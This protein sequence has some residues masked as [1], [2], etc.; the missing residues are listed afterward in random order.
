MKE[1]PEARTFTAIRDWRED[2]K[3]REKLLKKGAESLSDS[4]LLAILIRHG[5][6]GH[7]AIDVAVDLLN[8]YENITGLS[9][10]SAAEIRK[11]KGLGQ[12]KAVTIAAAFELG[13]RIEVPPFDPSNKINQPGDIARFYIPKFRNIMKENFLVLLLNSSN[14]VFKEVKISEGSLNASIV[15]PREVFKSAISESAAS[16]ILLHNHPSGNPT[17]SEEDK[18]IT[19]QLAEAGNII[20]I[21]VLDHIIIT[22]NAYFSF[23]E[24]GLIK[25]PE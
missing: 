3:P 15:H 14:I 24:R 2:D 22:A 20:D 16:V 8:K 9:K 12:A 6:K 23:A 4:E 18:K 11:T 17:P 10:L 25:N 13:K 21:R 7:S 19:H 5:T 1:Y